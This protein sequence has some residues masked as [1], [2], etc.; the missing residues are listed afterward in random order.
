VT[1]DLTDLLFLPPTCR[2]GFVVVHPRGRGARAADLRPTGAPHP[3]A[4]RFKAWPRGETRTLTT[5]RRAI[6]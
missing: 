1:L 4:G 6:S 3:N 2:A 5:A